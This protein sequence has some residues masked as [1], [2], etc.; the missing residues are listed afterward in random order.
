MAVL[1]TGDGFPN[2]VVTAITST[3]AIATDA[4]DTWRLLLDGKSGIR[5]LD[6]PFVSEFDLPVHIGG[7]LLE[8]FDHHLNRVE[9]RRFS[10]LQKMATVLSR[11][12]WTQ[13]G[14]DG[15]DSLDTRRLM[16]SIGLALGTAEEIVIQYDTFKEKGMR[17]VS[18][19]A[20]Q[21]YMPN[22]P[23]A[24][25]GLERQAQAGIVTPLMADA[26]GSAAI[27]EAWRH[28]V[29][30]EAD[31]AICGGIDTW[32]GPVTIAAFSQMDLLSTH[33]E[34]PAGACRPFDADRDGTVFSE[35]GAML[36]LESEE[37]AV[38]RGAPILGR[39]M[40]GAVTSDGYDPVKPDPSGESAAVAIG[41]AIELAG[42]T[43]DDIDLVTAD[44]AG[45]LPGDLAEAMALHLALGQRRPAVYAPKSALGHS[46]GASGAVDAVLTV[47]ALRDGVVPPTL[48]LTHLDPDVDL[49]VVAGAPRPGDYRYAL[50]DCF[51]FGG[52]NVALVFGAA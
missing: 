17:A 8:D 12:L 36:L 11:R 35:A 4:E 27:A 37:H 49:D 39:V 41:R 7:P 34:D 38:A 20:V 30:G 43:P 44:A 31:V 3:N 2:V 18:P 51:G 47:Q 25:V 10:Y 14:L 46:W 13:A 1:K 32:I 29:L 50:I 21:M 48:N 24:A 26:S 9:L 15:T 45:T 5:L 6:K 22:A 40:G 33:N 19:L 23:S 28:I 52:H 16:I 42:L